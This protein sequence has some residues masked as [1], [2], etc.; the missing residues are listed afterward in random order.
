MN[1]KKELKLIFEAKTVSD[2]TRS[3]YTPEA[4]E[5]MKHYLEVKAESDK[6]ETQLG[7]LKAEKDK[8][9]KDNL[10]F[11]KQDEIDRLEKELEP[12]KAEKERLGKPLNS[13]LYLKAQGKAREISDEADRKQY[14]R[15]LRLKNKNEVVQA[16]DEK[17]KDSI[18][19]FLHNNVSTSMNAIDA[20]IPAFKASMEG[21]KIPGGSKYLSRWKHIV[22]SSL[23]KKGYKQSD[24][25][26]Y[27]NNKSLEA[28]GLKK[29]NVD[30]DVK[31]E[32]GKR[33]VETKTSYE[34]TNEKNSYKAEVQG[35]KV[36]ISQ[37]DYEI[38]KK[39]F[40]DEFKK[41]ASGNM[42]VDQSWLN[43]DEVK[44]YLA[45]HKDEIGY[46]AESLSRLTKTSDFM[47]KDKRGKEILVTF[48]EVRN[49]GG[50]QNNQIDDVV[51]TLDALKSNYRASEK[52]KAIAVI[53]GEN[54]EN[55]LISDETGKVIYTK[56]VNNKI[57][58]TNRWFRPIEFTLKNGKVITIPRVMTYPQWLA[59]LEKIKRYV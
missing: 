11:T 29:K 38:L 53:K 25:Q 48:K 2:L 19:S 9:K 34:D 31:Y 27:L 42:I 13:P 28:L 39:V 24:A 36:I 16:S 57:I 49:Q 14:D 26:D 18:S 15:E 47:L 50:S 43:K 1:L 44:K 58:K 33:K 6:I 55:K 54:I 22:I 10:P 30:Y 40:P 12:I 3:T 41:E 23:A 35:N 17:F 56:K 37:D 51:N 20:D 21:E 52:N 8:A 45:D 46:T 32:N 59:F 5:S 7:K 4:G